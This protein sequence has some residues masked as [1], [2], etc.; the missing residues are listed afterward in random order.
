MCFAVLLQDEL[1]CGGSC[2]CFVL[3]LPAACS[4]L[5]DS[6]RN[7]WAMAHFGELEK[8]IGWLGVGKHLVIWL[9][10]SLFLLML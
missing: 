1:F 6:K 9:S 2:C 5:I 7:C 4:W 3:S 10:G 8:Q